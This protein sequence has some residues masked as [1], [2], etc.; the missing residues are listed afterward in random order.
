[1]T[2]P[3]PVRKTYV[4]VT[5]LLDSAEFE[6]KVNIAVLEF[7]CHHV[8]NQDAYMSSWFYFFQLLD[9]VAYRDHLRSI[10]QSAT[11]STNRII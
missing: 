6:Q 3:R 9:A 11:L 7:Y 4:V 2:Q 8:K 5:D 1:M 10:K